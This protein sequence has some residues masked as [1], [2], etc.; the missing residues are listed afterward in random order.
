MG[1]IVGISISLVLL[2]ILASTILW[3]AWKPKGVISL[4]LTGDLPKVSILIAVRDESETVENTINSLIAQDY[5]VEKLEVLFGDD[6]SID[7]SSEILK[8]YSEK[9]DFFHYFLIENDDVNPIRTKADVLAYL[10]NHVNDSEILMFTDGDIVVPPT[11]VSKHIACLKENTAIQS[12]FTII[13][14]EGFFSSMQMIDWSFA[15]GMVKIVTSWGIPVT[16]VGNNMIIKKAA[17]DEVGGFKDLPFTLTE[18]F[19]I[20]RK[21]VSMNYGFQQLANKESL[22][23]SAPEKSFKEL[24]KQRKRWMSGAMQLPFSMK[25]ILFLQAIYYP[26]IVILLIYNPLVGIPLFGLKI[27][28][29][30][31]FISKIHER[32]GEYMPIG[33]L[34]IFEFYSALLTVVLCVYYILPLPV[35]WKGRKYNNR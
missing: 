23:Y 1:I 5:P 30:S 24:L 7:G 25:L 19:S 18:D 28:V 13:K 20:F 15:L 6:G 12:G 35:E 32:L 3:F 11:W 14:K 21:I 4:Q 2:T 8:H 34:F 31:L 9:Y 16:A 33:H 10:A 26:L 17:Y 29:Q 27:T 22:A